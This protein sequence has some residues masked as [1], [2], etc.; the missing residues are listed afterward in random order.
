MILLYLVQDTRK[1]W[2]IIHAIQ[3]IDEG[4]RPL[5]RRGSSGVLLTLSIHTSKE[6]IMA[7]YIS[8]LMSWMKRGMSNKHRNDLL[9]WAQTEYKKDWRFAYQYM[10]DHNGRAP[11]HRDINGPT[12]PKEVA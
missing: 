7:H 2:R 5:H 4:Q 11:T 8:G 10:L 3:V 6:K 1:D 9:T 12:V